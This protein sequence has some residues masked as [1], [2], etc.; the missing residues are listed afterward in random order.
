MS[1]CAD[2]GEIPTSGDRN[3][4][5]PG[6]SARRF[7]DGLA[8]CHIVFVGPALPRCHDGLRP[9]N[10][11]ET[12]G[13]APGRRV[14]QAPCNAPARRISLD[15]C[16]KGAAE[17]PLGVVHEKMR[18]ELCRI[19]C[20]SPPRHTGRKAGGR[21]KALTHIGFRKLCGIGRSRLRPAQL[22]KPQ[23][24]DAP[25]LT[26]DSIARSPLV[27]VVTP[28]GWQYTEPCVNKWIVEP[29]SATTF[30]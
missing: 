12:D 17:L 29:V 28:E 10:R 8:R 3:R 18:L 6:E 14:L 20:W 24:T 25:T 4:R 22:S 30:N 15:R 21:A 9:T 23:L 2:T 1:S 5:C 26:K 16:F 27:S 19:A 11:H 13:D 7:A